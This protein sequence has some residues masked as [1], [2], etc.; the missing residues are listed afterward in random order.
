MNGIAGAQEQ[1]RHAQPADTFLHLVQKL[2]GDWQQIPNTGSQ[3]L[4]KKIL[5]LI[6]LAARQIALSNMPEKHASQL[7]PAPAGRRQTSLSFHQLPN[8]LGVRLV[9]IALRDVGCV[10]IEAQERSSSRNLPLSCESLG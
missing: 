9:E 4:A 5:Q 3:I 8:A 10:E 2:V 1:A 7:R 6:R